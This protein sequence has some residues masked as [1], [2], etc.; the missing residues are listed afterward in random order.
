MGDSSSKFSHATPALSYQRLSQQEVQELLSSFGLNEFSPA[1][2]RISL[3][4]FLRIFPPVL[5]PTASVLLPVLRDVVRMQQ[6]QGRGYSSSGFLTGKIDSSSQLAASKTP[7][8]STRGGLKNLGNLTCSGKGAR[9][10]EETCSGGI[11][12]TLQEMVDAVSAC[13]YGDREELQVHMLQRLLSRM[14]KVLEEQ[15]KRLRHQQSG[16][17]SSRHNID[18][19]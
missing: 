9:K 14:S 6:V 19:G 13:A 12:I 4:S 8:P 2:A 18:R 5:H 10:G 11:H 1:K 16:N 17:W 15:C 7:A 3:H